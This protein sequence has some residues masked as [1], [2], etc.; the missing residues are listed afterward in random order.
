MAQLVERSLPTSEINGSNPN[1]GKV[2]RI[3]LSLSV[4]RNSEKTKI[5]KNELFDVFDIGVLESTFPSP[6]A[7]QRREGLHLISFSF[8]VESEALIA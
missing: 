4:N 3:Y 8:D 2:Y 6:A 1:I 5:K 7:T